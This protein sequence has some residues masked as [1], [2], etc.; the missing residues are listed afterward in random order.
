MFSQKANIRFLIQY[1]VEEESGGGAVLKTWQDW[2]EVWGV[3]RRNHG[4][5]VAR[6]GSVSLSSGH[7]ITIRKPVFR[8]G[9]PLPFSVNG[10]FRII[11]RGTTYV[12]IEINEDRY[13][14]DIVVRGE[15]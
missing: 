2:Q 7:V 8:E 10:G 12:P 6:N 15:E 5:Q 4:S 3:L 14:W 13:F 11:S 1:P 9:E